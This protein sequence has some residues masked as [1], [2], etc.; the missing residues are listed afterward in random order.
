V[1]SSATPRS[2]CS[3]WVSFSVAGEARHEAQL[4]S[5]TAI[6]TAPLVP[7]IR[8]HLATEVTPLWEATEVTMA[9]VGLPPPFWAFAWPGGQALARF[10][11]DRPELL[12]GKRVL[13][14][15]AG[16][17]LTSIA[18][19][20]CGASQ[21]LASEIDLFA[22]DA[23]EV[24][25]AL[26]EVKIETTSADLID[27]DDGWDVVFAGDVCYERP[28]AERIGHWC[29]KLAARGALVLMGDPGRTYMPPREWL[30]DQAKYVVPTS[31]DL[32]DKE[33]RET[34]VWRFR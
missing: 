5:H 32:E 7:E 25:A 22:I 30:E 16:S 12:R 23:M 19:V 27:A 15:A 28:I 31:R 24:N 8:L 26:N 4:A 18:A 1:T 21:V 17:G 9:Q 34:T 10:V 11:L 14:F 6:A 20:R 3:R 29:R 13:D 33:S 2:R